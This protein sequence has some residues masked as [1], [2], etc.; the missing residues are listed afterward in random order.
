MLC[1]ALVDSKTFWTAGTSK[2]TS[3]RAKAYRYL[4][5]DLTESISRRSE[6]MGSVISVELYFF[7]SLHDGTHG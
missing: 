6:S 1:V 4:H 3:L 2:A 7:Y 5:R